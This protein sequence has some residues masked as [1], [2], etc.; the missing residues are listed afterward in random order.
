MPINQPRVPVIPAT[1]WKRPRP[2]RGGSPRIRLLHAANS[3]ADLPKPQVRWDDPSFS[4]TRL[5]ST[6]D[7][8][9]TQSPGP[10][11]ASKS[12]SCPASGSKAACLGATLSSTNGPKP[13]DWRRH[14]RVRHNA[15]SGRTPMSMASSPLCNAQKR[16]GPP[17]LLD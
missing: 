13:A 2:R 3:R 5:W 12:Q 4:R 6:R 11:L 1:G 17:R 16:A 14:H 10:E 8:A 7:G 15:S 9:R